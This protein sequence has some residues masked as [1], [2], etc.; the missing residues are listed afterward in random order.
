MQKYFDNHKVKGLVI[1]LVLSA[2]LFIAAQTGGFEGLKKSSNIQFFMVLISAG[3]A[4]FAFANSK[5][6]QYTFGNIFAHGF[7]TI[8]V[9]IIVVIAFLI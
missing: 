2:I 4:A 9:A 7:K 1:G 6:K 5:P 8:G 3:L